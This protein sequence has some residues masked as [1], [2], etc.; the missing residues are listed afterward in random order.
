MKLAGDMAKTVTQVDHIIEALETP[1]D[2]RTTAQAKVLKVFVHN[3]I[4]LMEQGLSTNDDYAYLAEH[5][6]YK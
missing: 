3:Q 4:P 1:P 5:L 2:E 6:K